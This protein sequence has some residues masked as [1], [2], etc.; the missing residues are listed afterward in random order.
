[1]GTK[2]SIKELRRGMRQKRVRKSIRGT[3]DRPRLCV[4]RSLRYTYAQLVSDEDGKTLFTVSTKSLDSGGKSQRCK[5]SA[6]ALGVKIAEL[7]KEK[8]VEN[9]VF[10]RNGFLFHGRVAAVAE[11][12]REGGLKF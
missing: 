10:D 3:N 11:G 4:Y 5:E 2:K 6:R 1:M 7:A 9:V 12:A 8:N